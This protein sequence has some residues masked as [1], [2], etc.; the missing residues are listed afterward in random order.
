VVGAFTLELVAW[1]LIRST[2]ATCVTGWRI[3]TL[4]LLAAGC[5]VVVALIGGLLGVLAGKGRRLV[6]ALALLLSVPATALLG[7]IALL[8]ACP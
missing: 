5:C 6:A 2:D 8:L 3:P 1:V 4:I 7:P